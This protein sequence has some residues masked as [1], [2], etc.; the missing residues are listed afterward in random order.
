M[1]SVGSVSTEPASWRVGGGCGERTQ[2]VVGEEPA[3]HRENRQGLPKI[4]PAG[5]P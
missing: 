5:L 1:D 3:G 2:R 4:A